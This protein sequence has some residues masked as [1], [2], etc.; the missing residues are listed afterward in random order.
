MEFLDPP[1]PRQWVTLCDWCR[2]YYWLLPNLSNILSFVIRGTKSRL[3]KI[4]L[5]I[6]I[7][8]C[9]VT[10]LTLFLFFFRYDRIWIYDVC[11]MWL[12]QKLLLII[13]NLSNI[14]SFVLRGTKSGLLKILL[15][16]LSFKDVASHI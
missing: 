11:F 14:L 16:I 2:N 6:L 3:L 12:V 9:C 15:L 1:L 10:Y 5:L 8:W 4:L 13:L 7:H